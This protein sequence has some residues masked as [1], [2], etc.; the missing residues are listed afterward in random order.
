MTNYTRIDISS[1]GGSFS[2]QPKGFW[3][4]Y[5]RFLYYFLIGLI[6]VG[7][8]GLKM[9]S[10]AFPKKKKEEKDHCAQ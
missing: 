5:F 8:K 9:H 4:N 1:G 6:W 7:E 2:Q 10:K 3:N